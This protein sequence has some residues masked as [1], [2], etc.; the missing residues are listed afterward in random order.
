VQ[1]NSLA[2]ELLSGNI[3]NRWPGE[4]K[5][6]I[7]CLKNNFMTQI[8]IIA[9]PLSKTLERKNRNNPKRSLLPH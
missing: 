3:E 9:L 6:L 1:Q 5:V 7:L 4:K 2:K 8:S